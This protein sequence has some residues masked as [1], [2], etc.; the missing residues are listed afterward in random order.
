[1]RKGVALKMVAILLLLGG[2]LLPLVA[3]PTP[4]G[5]DD[6]QFR[7]VVE[8]FDGRDD[9]YAL[10]LALMA[11]SHSRLEDAQRFAQRALA[12]NENCAEAWVVTAA[13][14][15]AAGRSSDALTAYSRAIDLGTWWKV[16]LRSRSYLRY[17]DGDT[18]KAIADLDEYLKSAP[19]DPS[20]LNNRAWFKIL[21]GD[22]AG[23]VQDAEKAVALEATPSHIDTRGWAR[24][25]AG[26]LDGALADARAVLEEDP[27][28]ASSRV[29]LYRI[30]T[31]RG[32]G[33]R[34]MAELR[35]YLNAASSG[36][37]RDSYLP[38][39]RFLLGELPLQELEKH[40]NWQVF[41]ILLR[42]MP[43]IQ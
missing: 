30:M 2:I 32:D 37:A 5:D 11:L 40:S 13:L 42:G 8:A 17:L 29:L 16:A 27:Q 39:V 33:A 34:A 22:L 36:G 4:T 24:Y 35:S 15:Q 3:Q 28:N 18:L 9:Y 25:H 19:D 12:A 20:A 41:R 6:E 38:A 26:Q 7:R 43:G 21:A 23:S 31:D 10:S 1:M 14:L